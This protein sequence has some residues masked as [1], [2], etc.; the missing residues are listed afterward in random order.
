MWVARK[1]ETDRAAAR[2]VVHGLVGG[3]VIWCAVILALFL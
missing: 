1:I 3:I 2:G